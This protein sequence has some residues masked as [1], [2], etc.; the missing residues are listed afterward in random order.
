MYLQESRLVDD[1]FNKPKAHIST[2]NSF[3]SIRC[4]RANVENARTA[5]RG[6]T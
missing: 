5:S 2:S 4:S 1:I 3:S 6:R